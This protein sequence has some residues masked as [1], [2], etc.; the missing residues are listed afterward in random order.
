MQ[1]Q[2]PLDVQSEL[3]ASQH[4]VLAALEAA[5]GEQIETIANGTRMADWAK[6]ILVEVDPTQW[7]AKIE[8]ARDNA[9]EL[10][11]LR[12]LYDEKALSCIGAYLNWEAPR[13]KMMN[14]RSAIHDAIVNA[15]IAHDDMERG[16]EH[17]WLQPIFKARINKASELH[18][19]DV[20]DWPDVNL[21]DGIMVRLQKIQVAAFRAFLSQLKDLRGRPYPT[22]LVVQGRKI[23]SFLNNDVDLRCVPSAPFTDC[24]NSQHPASKLLAELLEKCDKAMRAAWEADKALKGD[25][26]G[27]VNERQHAGR[28]LDF[29]HSDG[30]PL[31][32]YHCGGNLED[33]VKAQNER[34]YEY[35]TY[36][37]LLLA[38]VR[39]FRSL[40]EQTVE[41][42]KASAKEGEEMLAEMEAEKH[43][44]VD[45]K[46]TIVIIMNNCLAADASLRR[47]MREL[48]ALEK[49]L[50]NDLSRGAGTRVLESTFADTQK[51]YAYAVSNRRDELAGKP[52]KSFGSCDFA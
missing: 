34:R 30:T 9:D 15:I 2:S 43:N 25:Q 12:V 16:S 52:K 48:V 35:E 50:A 45:R 27:R 26:N 49:T 39:N 11:K 47:W 44:T 20:G 10:A 28:L 23:Q 33:Q 24:V 1:K 42:L 32:A 5:I 40:V 17:A 4:P 22:D 36:R 14:G 37:H 6:R 46:L 51:R 18:G 13:N 41:A 7:S 21:H 3:F 31:A 8:A 29:L 38:T 19:K